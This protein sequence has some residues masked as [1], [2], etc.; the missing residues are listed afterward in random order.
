METFFYK[1]PNAVDNPNAGIEVRQHNEMN[2]Q[3]MFLLRQAGL[4]AY[5]PAEAWT[6]LGTNNQI[7]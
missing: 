4:D 3:E 7:S 1:Y 2:E 6:A 5:A